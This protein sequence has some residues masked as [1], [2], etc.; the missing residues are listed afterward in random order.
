[1]AAAQLGVELGSYP[2]SGPYDHHMV[3]LPPGVPRDASGGSWL[4]FA[5]VGGQFSCYNDLWCLSVS[6]QV[7]EIGHN[8]GLGHA[9]EGT[10]RYGDQTGTM[11]YSVS[12]N[13][14]P[15]ACYNGPKTWQLGWTS[16]RNAEIEI[17]GLDMAWPPT[18]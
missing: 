18:R 16:D 7:H 1:V 15:M 9:G 3:C 2:G 5:A 13:D 6:A 10:E 14:G 12:P 4:A 17:G 11:G 8:L